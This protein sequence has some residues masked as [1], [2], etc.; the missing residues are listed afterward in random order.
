VPE[1]DSRTAHWIDVFSTLLLAVAAVATAWATYQAAHWRSE[2]GLAGNR[3]TAARVQAN[4]AAGVANRQ[5]VIDVET[6]TQWV[7][8]YSRG[9]AKLADFYFHRFRPEFRPAV[10][11]WVATKPLT[12]P[13]A[14]LTP[15]AMPQYRSAAL[16]DA[17]RLE[18]KG[19]AESE[20]SQTNVR[21]ADRYTLCVVLFATALFFAG[22]STRLRTDGT[23]GAVLAT[24]WV[25]FVGALAWMVTLPTSLGA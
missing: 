20:V 11:A 19:A 14:P 18:A 4:R 13:R 9:E 12:N 16:A 3:S 24:G 15:F 6:F 21:R 17:D 10:T 23:R 8:A 7:D 25:L 1:P 5:I 22:I 2:Q